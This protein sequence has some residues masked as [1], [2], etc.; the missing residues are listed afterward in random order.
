MLTTRAQL[1]QAYPIASD[2]D[3]NGRLQLAGCDAI[4]L[5]REF[6]TPAYIVVEDDLRARAQTFVEA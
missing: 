1:S 6:G 5:A 2:I 4:E 3:E